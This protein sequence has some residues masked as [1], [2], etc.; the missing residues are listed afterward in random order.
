MN[1]FDWL[2]W[3]ISNEQLSGELLDRWLVVLLAEGDTDVDKSEGV[4]S[5][6]LHLLVCCAI[7]TSVVFMYELMAGPQLLRGWIVLCAG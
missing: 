2:F 3:R 1:W 4:S 7:E 5:S 6:D